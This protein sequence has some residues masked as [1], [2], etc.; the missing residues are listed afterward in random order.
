MINIIHFQRICCYYVKLIEMNF[1][2]AARE[3]GYV[4]V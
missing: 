4:V 3:L 1:K 2:N